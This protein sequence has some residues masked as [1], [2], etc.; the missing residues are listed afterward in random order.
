MPVIDHFLY[1]GFYLPA[2]SCFIDCP[3]SL[4]PSPWHS[5][6]L[7]L[8]LLLSSLL[9]WKNL[10]AEGSSECCRSAPLKPTLH[11]ILKLVTLLVIVT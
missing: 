6:P 8:L 4:D 10:S 9:L 5:G 1:A 3:C 2:R 7:L 11:F